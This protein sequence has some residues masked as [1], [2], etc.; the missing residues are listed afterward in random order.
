[1]SSFGLRTDE[2]KIFL[3]DCGEGTRLHNI[4]NELFE[5]SGTQQQ[6]IKC[7][8]LKVGKI[9]VILITHLHGDHSFGL[10][11][12]VYMY[13]DPLN[14]KYSTDFSHLCLFMAKKDL[15]NALVHPE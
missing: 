8:D 6:F 3:I 4:Y 11:G 7:T 5:C 1:M 13:I 15:S 9:E 2:G 12:F 14:I 10:P